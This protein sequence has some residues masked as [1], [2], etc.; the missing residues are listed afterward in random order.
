M[1]AKR[2]TL[3]FTFTIIVLIF[4]VNTVSFSQEAEAEKNNEEVRGY[5]MIGG[6]QLDIDPLN[7]RL[8][9]QNNFTFSDQFFSI[10]GGFHRIKNER[11]LFG[12]EGH[13]LANEEQE[14]AAQNVDYKASLMAAYGFFDMG[15]ILVSSGGL[16]IYPL[17]GF[18]GGGSWLQIGKKNFNDILEDPVRNA[19]LTSGA[20]LLNFAVGADYLFKSKE[21]KEHE[22][23]FVMGFRAGYTYTPWDGAWWTDNI[24]VEGG[25]DTGLTGAYV[26]FMIGFGGK[27]EWWNE[28]KK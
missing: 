13:F 6:N 14:F 24:S 8:L 16:D 11:W 26:R 25:P 5:L 20:F 9:S 4:F 12:F 18:G 10:G 7:E 17:I 19:Q 1:K 21:F 15:Y 3:L 27:G 2:K 28:E 23:G 22:A